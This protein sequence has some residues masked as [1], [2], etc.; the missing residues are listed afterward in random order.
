MRPAGVSRRR[1]RDAALVVAA[2]LLVTTPVAAS[3]MPLRT[4]PTLADVVPVV[5]DAAGDSAG[6]DVVDRHDEADLAARGDGA[7]PEW[8][9]PVV[10]YETTATFGD[11]GSH[12]TTRHTGLD[13]KAPRGTPVYAVHAGT[14]VKLAWHKAYGRMV[15][16]EVSPGVTVWYCHLSAVTVKPGPVEVGQQ[17]GRIGSTGNAFGPH[18]HLEV[19]VHDRPTDPQVYLFGT[20]PGGTSKPPSW[21]PPQAVITVANLPWLKNHG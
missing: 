6:A 2:A 21:L 8:M 13:F 5:D 18:L 20:P 7:V 1:L 3:A 19:R 16:L 9:L 4:P 11:R 14:V 15:I 12:W 17:L 10:M